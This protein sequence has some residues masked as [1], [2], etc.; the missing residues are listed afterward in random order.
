MLVAAPSRIGV[1]TLR[2][3]AG[4]LDDL[5][6][7]ADTAL[8]EAKA[9]GRDRC[10]AWRGAPIVNTG[11]L[12]GGTKRRVLKAGRITFN[13]G[14]SVIDCTVRALSDDEAD[15]QVVSTAG[16]PETFKL[17]IEADGLSRVCRVQAKREQHVEVAFER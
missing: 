5:L 16:V 2:A 13:R 3:D 12:R 11:T 17:R 15:L 1:A 4:D 10:V 6:R 9:Q 7:R 8:Y 14:R